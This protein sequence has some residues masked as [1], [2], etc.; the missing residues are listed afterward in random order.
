VC[1]PTDGNVASDVGVV[2][3]LLQKL[4]VA[5]ED[6]AQPLQYFR[7]VEDL[8]LNQLLRDRE[9]HLRAGNTKAQP[10]PV[11]TTSVQVGKG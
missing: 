5:D 8:V 2:A 1:L 3:V 6:L 11:Q 9:K 10:Q 4:D 7:V